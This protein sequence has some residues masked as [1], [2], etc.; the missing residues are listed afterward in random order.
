[1]LP[2]RVPARSRRRS[3]LLALGLTVLIG[4]G[5]AAGATTVF[6][7]RAQD[8]TRDF[9]TRFEA[10]LRASRM[11]RV[12]NVTYRRGLTESTQSMTVT[13]RPGAAEQAVVLLVMNHIQHGPF[14]GLRHLGQAVVNTEV[15]LADSAAQAQ[16]DRAFAGRKPVIQTV[17][18]FGGDTN[19]RVEVPTGRLTEDGS[20]V[21]WQP[22]AG[23]IRVSGTQSDTRL[24][25]P[26]L[27]VQG[28]DGQA[29]LAGVTLS[30]G[31][32]RQGPGD[33]LGLGRS[34]FTVDRLTFRGSGE[35]VDLSG[36][37]VSS[38]SRASG[39]DHLDALVSY[40]V[41]EFSAT[42]TTLRNVGLHLGLRHLARAP[43]NRL[44]N[45]LGEPQA[46]DGAAPQFSAAQTAQM[47][48]DL[49][50][51]LRGSPR[52]TLDRLSLRQSS[53]DVTLTG[54]VGLG[55]A[56][57][58]SER[59]LEMLG[60]MPQML[61]GMLDVRLDARASEKALNG[62]LA[63]FGQA[64]GQDLSGMVKQLA[65]AGY[66]ERRGGQLTAHFSMRGG[67]PLLNGQ[68]LGE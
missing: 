61:A 59:E 6:S 62:L 33:T 3:P 42:G 57:A 15:R 55:G 29:Q 14:P 9:T 58:L 31:S 19:T 56:A 49:M 38:E 60:Q 45:T 35:R 21:T 67:Q 23:N 22:L 13:L 41:G 24:N 8:V 43:L 64:G 10:G 52:L 36:L 32:R 46:A 44:L 1:M 51:L 4:A 66:V 18:G 16:L 7:S 37:K 20:T 2:P 12:E 48:T 11:A 5:A 26:G 65:E 40:D 47:K 28:Q 39:P 25:W 63:L 50:A 68:A 27:T 17:I 54:E 34:S 53:G 30:S